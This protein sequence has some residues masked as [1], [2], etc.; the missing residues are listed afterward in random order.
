MSYLLAA[1]HVH[2][3]EPL[4]H[5]G[6]LYPKQASQMNPDRHMKQLPEQGPINGSH[7]SSPFSLPQYKMPITLL[8]KSWPTGLLATIHFTLQPTLHASVR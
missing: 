5:T 3:T 4:P 8:L 7:V 1:A 6:S 2:H